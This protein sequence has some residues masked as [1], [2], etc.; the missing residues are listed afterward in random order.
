MSSR[1]KLV[2]VVAAVVVAVLGLGVIILRGSPGNYWLTPDEFLSRADRASVGA[3][4]GGRI[5]AGSLQTDDRLVVFDIKAAG[6]KRALPVAYF[7]YVPENFSD[8]SEVIVEGAWR[9]E[10]FVADKIL[11]RC[12]E[13]YLPEKATIAAYKALG[14]QGALYR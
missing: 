10:A 9:D 4:I 11:V 8:L 3:R 5:V 6:E 2:T 14:I 7:G 12:P 13:N 1:K